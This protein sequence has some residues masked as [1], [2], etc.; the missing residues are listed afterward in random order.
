MELRLKGQF[1]WTRAVN[2]QEPMKEGQSPTWSTNFIPS[3]EALEEI[4]EL[5]GKGI[6]NKLKKGEEDNKWRV[7]FSRPVWIKKM[8]KKTDLSPPKI[9]GIANPM[10]IGN[11]TE[12]EIIL[13]IYQHATPTGGTAVAARWVGM[14]VTKLVEYV[15]PT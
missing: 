8:G 4:R 1:E 5:Q 2:P 7:K 6:K 15:R 12:G 3:P 11:G 9:D 14:N 13:D 10:S